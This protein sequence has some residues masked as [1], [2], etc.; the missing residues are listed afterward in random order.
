MLAQE[1]ILRQDIKMLVTELKTQ[2]KG[3]LEMLS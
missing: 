3:N 1:D 2:M